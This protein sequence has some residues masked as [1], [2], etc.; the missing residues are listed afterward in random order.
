M[1]YKCYP[2]LNHILNLYDLY[3]FAS[4]VRGYRKKIENLVKAKQEYEKKHSNGFT[5][6]EE[7]KKYEEEFEKIKEQAEKSENKLSKYE[8]EIEDSEDTKKKVFKKIVEPYIPK[9]NDIDIPE[10]SKKEKPF[11]SQKLSK[12]TKKEQK[13]LSRVYSIINKV[14]PK[15][16]AD[17][18]MLKIN[19]EFE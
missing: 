9:V 11:I 17:N 4:N 7:K 10:N 15:E 12:L 1:Y 14:L 13:F 8:N 2:F 3:Y 16:T 6:K 19:E 5:D 18:L